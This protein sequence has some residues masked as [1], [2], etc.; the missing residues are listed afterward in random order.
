MIRLLHPHTLDGGAFEALYRHTDHESSALMQ[1]GLR[2]TDIFVTYV[3]KYTRREVSLSLRG[4]HVNKENDA[5]A[6]HWIVSFREF[7]RLIRQTELLLTRRRR[8][9]FCK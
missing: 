7:G 2:T 3:G 5:G 6:G 9:I 4:Q 8:R 1:F